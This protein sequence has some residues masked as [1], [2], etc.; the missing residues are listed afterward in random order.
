MLTLENFLVIRFA[1]TPDFSHTHHKCPLLLGS[2]E[3]AMAKFGSGVNEFELDGL[4]GLAR[5]VHD[6][7]LG[8]GTHKDVHVLYVS[9]NNVPFTLRL[10]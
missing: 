9:C 2:L 5:C 7:R 8:G 1:C 4:L 10:N 3:A 6:Q